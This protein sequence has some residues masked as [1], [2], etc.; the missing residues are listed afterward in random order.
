MNTCILIQITPG[1]PGQ[2][3]SPHLVQ[4]LSQAE[5]PKMGT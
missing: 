3:P 4:V 5:Q 2:N 1:D